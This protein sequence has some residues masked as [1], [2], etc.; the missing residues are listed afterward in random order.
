MR[1]E[2]LDL[3]AVAHVVVAKDVAVVPEFLDDGGGV[4]L[5]R[6]SSMP[7][8]MASSSALARSGS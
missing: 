6:F 1:G 2:L 7:L 8:S 4:H 5:W 3:V